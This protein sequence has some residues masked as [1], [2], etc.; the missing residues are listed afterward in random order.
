MTP[1]IIILVVFI[2]IVVVWTIVSWKINRVDAPSYIIRARKK[3]YEI[4]TY[5]PY[6]VAEVIVEGDRKTATNTGFRILASYIFGGN[7]TK[8]SL[9]MTAPIG[10]R[11]SGEA[12]TIAM[13]APVMTR[14]NSITSHVISFVMPRQETPAT[15]PIP[16]DSRIVF[17]T[18]PSR[19]VAV[20]KFSW[21][22][23]ESRIQ[24]KKDAL[25]SALNRDGVIMEGSI[26]YA[27]YTAPFTVPFLERHEVMVDV[28]E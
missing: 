17:N 22:I 21:Y 14:N 3:D 23:S 6:T 25:T 9:A 10:E 18:V 8:A 12:R 7:S 27:G 26:S 4:R 19:T 24:A 13:T 28:R 16:N 11:T 2:S 20:M 15:L 5:E 1:S